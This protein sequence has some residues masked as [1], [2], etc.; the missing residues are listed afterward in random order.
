MDLYYDGTSLQA[1]ALAPTG[2]NGWRNWTMATIWALTKG[3]KVDIRNGGN[4]QSA[5]ASGRASL[6]IFR[7][8]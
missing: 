8:A 5:Q 7:V 3:K 6:C 4:V 2:S 1:V